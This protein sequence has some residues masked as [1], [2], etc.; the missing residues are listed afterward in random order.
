[1]L[2]R[3]TSGSQDLE[4]VAQSLGTSYNWV[5]E[6]FTTSPCGA[7]WNQAAIDE[8]EAGYQGEGTF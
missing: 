8:M 3:S 7:Q 5:W 2:L 1:M 6:R 4:G